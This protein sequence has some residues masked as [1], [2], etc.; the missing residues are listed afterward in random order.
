MFTQL[1]TC[2]R[3]LKREDRAN[4]DLIIVKS[5]PVVRT[6]T[7][8]VQIIATDRPESSDHYIQR[9]LD[10][11][12]IVRAVRADKT[13]RAEIIRVLIADVQTEVGALKYALTRPD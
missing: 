8:P 12:I 7:L 5:E 2:L 13:D 11:V 6:F 10:E 4:S 3:G 1:R 9:R